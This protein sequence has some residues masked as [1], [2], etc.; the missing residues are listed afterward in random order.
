LTIRIQLPD[1]ERNREAKIHPYPFHIGL[2]TLEFMQGSLLY[3]ILVD[4]ASGAYIRQPDGMANLERAIL[5]KLDSPKIYDDAWKIIGK[6]QAVFEK[7]PFQ[8]VLIAMNS[9]WDWYA[10]KLIDF[11]LFARQDLK[12]PLL[13][14]KVRD[15]LKRFSSLPIG[16]QLEAI[17]IAA[18]IKFAL[19]EEEKSELQEM[20]LVRNLGL[21][22]RWEI[23]TRYLERTVRS[24]YQLGELRIIEREEL[25]KWH[26][27]FLR[28]VQA[29]N[30]E[31]A[32]TFVKV[33]DYP[34]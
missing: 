16:E 10:R 33:N 28:V 7:V 23:D 26:Q 11:I 9:H 6:Y 18:G 30:I 32:M 17:E 13:E 1:M 14:K 2:Q 22:N 12:Q 24:G 3:A 29:T 25:F 15:Q 5:E 27:V 34:Q 20:T 8:S 31:V 19:S 4:M 21:H